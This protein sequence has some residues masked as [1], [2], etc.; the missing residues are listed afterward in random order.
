MILLKEKKMV[1]NRKRKSS[2]HMSKMKANKLTIFNMVRGTR[3][4]GMKNQEKEIQKGKT[5]RLFC[6]GYR[7]KLVRLNIAINKVKRFKCSNLLKM[8]IK[9]KIKTNLR[10]KTIVC[11]RKVERKS[12]IDF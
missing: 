6:K 9:N 10:K 3:F 2:Y 7:R 11:N 1:Q 12:L 8:R 5:F 4:K